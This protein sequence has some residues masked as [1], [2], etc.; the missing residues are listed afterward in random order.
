MKTTRNSVLTAEGLVVAIFF[1]GLACTAARSGE[2]P[3]AATTLPEFVIPQTF[4]LQ[5]KGNNCSAENLDE[6][7]GLG[8]A[9]VRRGFAWAD[10]EKEK[11]VYNFAGYD[12]LLEDTKKRGLRVLGCIAFDN[13]LY[14]PVREA[15]GRAAYARFAAALAARYREHHILWEIWNE[16]NT[17]TFW[18]KH[19]KKGN[20][21]QYATEYTALVKEV[22]PAMRKADP[23]CFIMGGSVSCLWP[24]SYLWTESCFKQGILQSGIDAW[25]VHPY[26]FKSP[27]EYPD[28][29]A[30]VRKLMEQYAAPKNFPLLNSERGY[31]LKKAEGWAG[32]PASLAMQFQAWH[33][34]RQYLVDM[35][36]DVRLTN[37]YEWTGEEFGIVRGKDHLPAYD[38][39]KVM[40]EQLGG[41]RLV[42]RLPLGTP[43]EAPLDFAL[44]FEKP[45]GEQKL[46]VWTA[47]PADQSPDKTK[48]HTVNLPIDAA[49]PLELCDLFGKKS[50]FT[51]SDGKFTVT[52][53]GSPQYVMLPVKPTAK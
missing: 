41:Y 20:S 29:Y 17:M 46:V 48:D 36:C 22:V 1:A 14:G 33:L 44:L 34:V 9:V 8:L 2:E 27:E 24:P 13:K 53:T 11:G 45:T 18:G 35:L 3:V 49:G 25:S 52:L 50:P 19:G 5:L 51:V 43:V 15:D 47:P 21:E 32:G 30:K 6:I 10:T 7:R 26:G 4:G 31:P 37:W 12:R 40:T 28:A 16:P 42:K 38:A 23:G 39:C